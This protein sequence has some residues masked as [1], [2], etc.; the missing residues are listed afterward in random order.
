M[1][2]C[3][4][5]KTE[6]T[7]ISANDCCS[8]ACCYGML[9]F[10]RNFSYKEILYR[11]ENEFVAKFYAKALKK[12][13]AILPSQKVGGQKVKNYSVYIKEAHLCKMVMEAFGY[14]QGDRLYINGDVFKK[15]C[16]FGA[17]V[18]GAFLVCG[19]MSDPFKNYH[20]EFV[21]RD[22]SLALEFYHLLT[23]YGLSPKRSMRRN[24]M[25]IYFN[26]SE[27]IE[28]ILTLMGA[29]SKVFEVIDVQIAKTIR[30]AENRKQNLD[31][32]NIDKQVEASIAQ[33][34]A[35][36]YLIENGYFE[37]LDESLKA[38][39]NLRLKYPN[40]SLLELCK[41]SEE[42]LTRSGLN[43]RLKKIME[44]AKQK[45]EKMNG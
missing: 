30:N 12:H 33:R 8:V 20:V 25:V 16:C 19:Q 38:S 37:G 24:S 23:E 27:T 44:I 36:E 18:R 39:A 1:S 29:T 4:E 14:N 11:S 13:F 31:I 15:E 22:L 17:F 28:E 9:L 45:K 2:F 40:A 32:G 5:V 42:S 43:H 10:G 35:I 26:Q 41:L 21:I 3:T 34:K 7:N 6:L